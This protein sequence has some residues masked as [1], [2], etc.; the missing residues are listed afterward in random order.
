MSKAA[1]GTDQ[2]LKYLYVVNDQNKVVR[3]AVKLGTQQEELQVIATGLQP[4][5]H[6]IVNGLQH[7]HPGDVVNPTLVA[8]PTGD[9][10][11]K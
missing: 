8:M 3:H 10:V 7:I 4:G 9:K 2:N 11:T 1:V 6:V 5:E